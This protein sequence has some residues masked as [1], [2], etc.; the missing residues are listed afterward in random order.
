MEESLQNLADSLGE[1]LQLVSQVLAGSIS[2]SNEN[3][4]DSVKQGVSGKEQPIQCCRTSSIHV[5][6]KSKYRIVFSLQTMRAT[7]SS[8]TSRTA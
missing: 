1:C 6:K 8:I 5:A 7:S 3:V 2:S 4:T